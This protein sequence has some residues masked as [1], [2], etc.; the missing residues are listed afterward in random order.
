MLALFFCSGATALIYEV[1][2]SK[3]LAQMLGSTV[4][5]QTVVLAV[6]MGGLALGNR[7]FGGI[8][9]RL[10]RPI[11]AYGLI[12][13][14]IGLYAFFFPNL[15]DLADY[16]FV[17]WG[18]PLLDHPAALTA[19]KGTLSLILLVG[20][21]ILMGGT[22]PLLAAFLQRTNLDAG[23][24]A[25]RFYSVNSLG[26]VFGAFLA[27]FYLVQH[28]GMVAALQW[29]AL[30]NLGIA[31]CALWQSHCLE[32][33]WAPSRVPETASS[34]SGNEEGIRWASVLVAITGG[35]SMGLEVLSSRSIAMLFGSSLQSFAIVLMAFIL[36]IGLG[37]ALVASPRTRSWNSRYA[38]VLCLLTASLW[39]GLMVYRIESWVEIFRILRSGLGRSSM[40]YIYY[41]LLTACLAMLVLGL[42]AALIGAVL[43]LLIRTSTQ[44]AS[45][46]R[47][48]GR[49]LTWNTLGAVAGVLL[50]GFLFMPK[51][52]LRNAYLILG[53]GLAMVALLASWH[54]RLKVMSMTSGA[55]CGLLIL[56]LLLGKE[57][58]RCVMSSGAFRWR[59]TE[60]NPQA[61]QL[62]KAHTKILFY[63]DAADATVSIEQNNE[64]PEPVGIRL[65]INGKVDASN[66]GDLSTQLLMGHIPMAARPEAK[67]VFILGLGSGITGGAILAHPVEHLTI[68]E[69][70]EPVIR[71]AKFFK[72]LN[73]GVLN[74]PLA[75]IRCEDARTLLKLSPRKYDL[76]ITEPSNPWTAGVGSV[77][78]QEFY[79][80]AASRLKEGGLVAQWFH[81]YE[82]HDEIVSLVLRTFTSV[83]PHMEVWDSSNGDLILLGSAKPWPSH[84]SVY[85]R[86]FERDEVRKDFDR[87]GIRSPEALWARQLAS[88][89]TA[90]AIPGPGPVQSDAFPILEY[91]APR[92]FYIG[93]TAQAFAQF[94]ERTWQMALAP[95]E[96][97]RTLASLEADVVQRIFVE[98]GSANQQLR[99]HLNGLLSSAAGASPDN[100]FV[101][102]CVF[103]NGLAGTPRLL[104]DTDELK[105]LAAAAAALEQ[106]GPAK[107]EAIDAIL[108]S[109]R[110]A[111]PPAGRPVAHYA[112][113]AVRACLSLGDP[114]RAQEILLQALRIHPNDPQLLYLQRISEHQQLMSSN[115]SA[116]KERQS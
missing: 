40:G 25:A 4:Y 112:A 90:F 15:Y 64:P 103:K 66:T 91:A 47:Q 32:E 63:E 69:N 70:C 8:A 5:A 115:K 2:W 88:H 93:N 67:D 114:A 108:A 94:D 101:L 7:W 10:S 6:F 86:I 83:F 22:L 99:D 79:Q 92:A 46:G 95:A 109:L 100:H 102:P 55:A 105:K 73:R 23:R 21:T 27:G 68:A 34:G 106:R 30:F 1:V 51:L 29:A 65:R 71:A 98:F 89:G 33:N 57:D 97:Q 78:S 113:S 77:F 16:A 37:S 54:L 61:L 50:T 49:L 58:W 104:D 24:S 59:E 74:N 96:K 80:L 48:V 82:L 36:G 56:F 38:L 11:H 3:Y 60:V 12:E 111:S 41:Q 75:R 110:A 85:A 26:A 44:D 116:H 42:P 28:W 20:P 76:I 81:V 18:T 72:P 87:I 39:I 13:F 17:A 14:C 62:R 9:D 35:V 52:G 31:T 19:L 43:P 45:L 53:L 107:I 84:P